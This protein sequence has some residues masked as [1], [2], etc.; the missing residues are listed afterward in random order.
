MRQESA[1][2]D[3]TISGFE[4]VLHLGMLVSI[5]AASSYANCLVKGNDQQ[6]ANGAIVYSSGSQ[7]SPVFLKNVTFEDNEYTHLLM[8]GQVDCCNSEPTFFSDEE[9]RTVF[10]QYSESST[11]FNA[12]IASST[13]TSP[14]SDAPSS[15]F[16]SLQSAPIRKTIQV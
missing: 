4:S 7:F 1:C 3:S 14:L 15:K 16:L 2:A 10:V 9:D 5:G 12:P 8:D 6:Y 11:S 13:P